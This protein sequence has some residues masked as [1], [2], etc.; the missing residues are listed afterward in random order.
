[1]QRACSVFCCH[2]WPLWLYHTFQNIIQRIRFSGK[3]TYWIQNDLMLIFSNFFREIF[4]FLRRK[5]RDTMIN[6]YQP[7][8]KVPVIFLRFY[9]NFNFLDRFSKV[10]EYQVTWKSLQLEPS[11]TIWTEGMTD[12]LGD[13]QTW[14]INTLS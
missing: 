1:M 7:S 4:S 11:C 9:W 6:V 8:C 13:R 14:L 3:K 10:F 2:L 5:Q 12:R